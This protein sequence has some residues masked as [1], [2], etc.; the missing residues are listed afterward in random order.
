MNID[1]DYLDV[2]SPASGSFMLPGQRLMPGQSLSSSSMTL[3]M[4][5]DGNLVASLKTGANP[6]IAEWSSN[7]S[8]NPGAYAVMQ[9]D[10]NL[11]VYSQNG[12]PSVGGS[13]WSTNTWGNPG[14]YAV[15]QDDGNLV[16]YRQGGGPSTGG[17]LWAS[18][19]SARSQTIGSGQTLKPGQWTQGQ[20]VLLVMQRDGNLVMYRKRDGAAIWSS[21]TW[22]HSGAYAVMQSDGNLVVY[23]QGGGALWATNTWGHA[24]AYAVMQD[25]GNLV[26]YRQGGGP[27]T[28]GALWA[29]NTWQAAR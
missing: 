16:V 14:A 9:S 7:T 26:V 19:S 13:L 2:T 11:V 21:G 23:G 10:G 4:Q 5:T 15:M 27:S 12:A 1:G 8:G 28:G 6:G 25:D 3:T 24:G 18:G 17:A 20:Y 29:S 22:G